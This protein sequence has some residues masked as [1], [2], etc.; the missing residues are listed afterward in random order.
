LT[1]AKRNDVLNDFQEWLLQ[2]GSAWNLGFCRILFFAGVLTIYGSGHFVE[3]AG[4]PSI[5]YDPI[6][7]FGHLPAPFGQLA[8]LQ[9]LTIVWFVSLTL[10]MF[11]AFTRV[12]TIG[13]ALIGAYL[14]G[15]GH[16]YGFLHHHENPI[17]MIMFLLA[18]SSCGD[19]LSLDNLVLRR[20][21]RMPGRPEA[22]S[23]YGW[24]IRLV[25]LV[26]CFTYFGAGVSKIACSGLMWTTSGVFA[27]LVWQA[28]L[29]HPRQLCISQSVLDANPWIGF[30]GASAGLFFELTAP[31]LLIWPKW[32][33]F[34]VSALILMHLV[35][36]YFTGIAYPQYILCALFWVPWNRLLHGRQAA[37]VAQNQ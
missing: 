13:S 25:W 20:F 30:I 24:P 8:L 29:T 10:S 2:D 11:G 16:N 4:V 35:L 36:D 3:W 15:L 33:L 34:G 37:A 12:A 7:F 14:L 21:K 32:R 31:A 1:P 6:S 22:D 27:D 28:G 19:R 5:F 26:L 18:F 9:C 23:R 17:V